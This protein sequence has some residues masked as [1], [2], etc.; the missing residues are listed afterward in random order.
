VAKLARELG[1]AL[2]FAHAAGI[3]HRDIKPE[4]VLF[5]RTGAKIADFGIARIPESTITRA[6]AVLGT[7]A[8]TSPEALSSGD[9]GAASD[10]FAFAATLYEAATGV[11]AFEGDDPIATAGKVSSEPPPPLDPALGT[12]PVVRTLWAALNKGMAKGVEGRFASC[13]D[14]GEAVA[15]AIERPDASDVLFDI[16]HTP[17][18]TQLPFDIERPPLSS[19][20]NVG[21]TKRT[22]ERPTPLLTPYG[23]ETPIRPSIVIR[24]QTHRWQNLVA[25]LALGV[26]V[27]LVVIGKK[28][29]QRH[30][31]AQDSAKATLSS[32]P[33]PAAQASVP[34]ALPTVRK[35]PPRRAPEPASSGRNDA[36][37]AL[38]SADA[39]VDVP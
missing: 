18:R 39:S 31:D 34:P 22:S 21:R 15:R 37:N 19:R 24:K 9:F 35:F 8:Y 27:V 10:Q 3:V 23:G 16:A 17:I 13:V 4:N 7:P 30:I 2:S 14:L 32:V 6:N 28:R 20:I 5:S 12:A 29:H 36:G 1:S 26:I 38:P 33:L 25:S 11:R